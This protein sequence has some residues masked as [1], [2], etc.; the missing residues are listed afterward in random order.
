MNSFPREQNIRDFLP[1]DRQSCFPIDTIWVARLQVAVFHKASV[2]SGCL[3]A[4]GGAFSSALGQPT[5]GE[6]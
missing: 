2:R 4:N 6:G 3:E 5:G 1:A